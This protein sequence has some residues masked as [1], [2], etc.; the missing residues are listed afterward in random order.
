MDILNTLISFLLGFTFFVA[1][2][3]VHV[4]LFFRVYTK[5][6]MEQQGQRETP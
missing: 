1:I 2:I 4:K 6:E 3:V 5:D